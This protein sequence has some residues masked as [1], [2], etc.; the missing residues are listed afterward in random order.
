[1]CPILRDKGVLLR[2]GEEV[3]AVFRRLVPVLLLLLL[4]LAAPRAE[5]PAETARRLLAEADSA[6]WFALNDQGDL[7]TFDLG[8]ALVEEAEAIIA[9]LPDGQL[10]DDLAAEAE[11]LA[12]A[13]AG[14]REFYHDHLAAAFPLTRFYATSILLDDSSLG[15]HEF[16]DD[17]AERAVTQAVEGLMQVPFAGLPQRPQLDVIF[18]VVPSDPVLEGQ[19]LGLVNRSPGFFVRNGREVAQ[20]LQPFDPS[21]GLARRVMEGELDE[22]LAA[23]LRAA[24]GSERLLAVTLRQQT[25]FDGEA[26]YIA[27]GRVFSSVTPQEGPIDRAY[28]K[29]FGRDRTDLFWPLAAVNLLFWG[30]AVG[31]YRLLRGNRLEAGDLLLPTL[32]FLVGRMTPWGLLPLLSQVRPAGSLYMNGA[33]WW[34]ALAGAALLAVP[35]LLM[36]SIGRR[37]PL[38]APFLAWERGLEV[39]ALAA[40]AGVAAW[41][42]TPLL[43]LLQLPGLIE[44]AV[45]LPGLLSAAWLIARLVKGTR[46]AALA[47]PLVALALGLALATAKLDWI[48]AGTALALA[49]LIALLPQRRAEATAAESREEPAAVESYCS[50]GML[51]RLRAET[52]PF[53]AG[54]VVWLSVTGPAGSGKSLQVQALLAA[55][56]K[57]GDLRQIVLR[58]ACEALADGAAVP[59]APLQH[60]LAQHLK[61]DVAGLKKDGAGAEGFYDLL[62]GPLAPL[63]SGEMGLEA[64]ERDLFHFIARTLRQEAQRARVVLVIDDAQWLD[65]GTGALLQYLRQVLPPGAPGSLLVLL[66]GRREPAAVAFGALLP[67]TREVTLSTL[68]AEQQRRLL[69]EGYGLAPAAADWV[70]DWLGG[71]QGQ[72]STA[73]ALAEVV[74]QLHRSQALQPTPAGFDFAP[75][76]DR[77]DPPLSASAVA[78][79]QEA[80]ALLPQAEDTL[81][82][83]ACLGRRFEASLVAEAL[84]QPRQM[85]LK[86]LNLL[87]R[88]TGLLHDLLAEDDVYAFRSQRALDAVRAVLDLRLRGPAVAAV[89]QVVRERHAQVARALAGRARESLGDLLR[90]ATHWYGA[91]RSYA[92][93]AIAANLE[94]ARRLAGLLRF[95]EAESFRR[96]A[97]DYAGLA[98]RQEEVEALGLWL[99]AERAHVTGVGARAA[100][101]AGLAF[102]ARGRG[103]RSLE[104]AVARACYEAGRDGGPSLAGEAERLGLAV[105]GAAEDPL[106][107]AEGLH[108]AGLALRFD[109]APE[110]LAESRRRLAEALAL[111]ET[112]GAAG[113]GLTAQI[114]NSLALVQLAPGGEAAEAERLFRR[115]L[116]LKQR[117]AIPD[118]PGLARSY[119]GLGYL[120]LEQGDPARLAEAADYL[121]RDIELAGE[122]G[123][124]GGLS[125][126]QLWLGQCLLRQGD[127][128]GAAQ[129]F[130]AVVALDLTPADRV[131]ALAGLMEA[132]A[133]E[134]ARE[135]YLARL[136][137]LPAAGPLPRESRKALERALAWPAVA[138]EPAVLALQARLE[139]GAA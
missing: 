82:I 61:L 113:E 50:L 47:A 139:E 125:K 138:A 91:G 1:M 67:L 76:F 32:G 24:F 17:A 16:F 133:A 58:G 96:Q 43:M 68:T 120:L 134:G 19:A 40:G 15:S 107:K 3:L 77:A 56:A 121:R 73:G 63:L 80:L 12:E 35:V 7:A 62:L 79:V 64:S 75:G 87:E 106:V 60:C 36:N 37:L 18:A 92:A 72:T 8:L 11:A 116:A 66:S 30:L 105:A 69:A 10:R 86:D 57:R 98:G 99:A 52:Q 95:E 93:E 34:P 111:A 119:G 25:A 45:A 38:V 104:L 128:A 22:P 123:D 14:Q 88:K 108:F 70:M 89:P 49:P 115:S 55:L 103:D 132:A 53:E 31:L 4:P 110:R 71:Q 90:Q 59:F 136:A 114:A 51:E 122:I 74:D 131:S 94:A 83:A 127:P 100:A 21:G 54:Q 129:A 117:Q 124:R 84:G 39:F 41:F 42:A 13:L 33:A 44:L 23:L 102:L 130:Q 126:A 28:V 27:E 5:E 48:A 20:A 46:G 137:A 135:V 97:E 109:S 6:S 26:F 101:E 78:E 65:E 112:A 81:S 29:G 2:R 118:R 9:T 85:V